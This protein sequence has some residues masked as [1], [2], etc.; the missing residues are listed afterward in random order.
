MR[1]AERRMARWLIAFALA[2]GSASAMAHEPVARCFLLDETTVR[3]RGASNDGDAMPGARM[4]VVAL[5]GT[6]LVEGKLDAQS[7][8]T[9]S[10]PAQPFYVLLDTGPGL[11]VTVEQ[12]EITA[13]PPGRMPRWM[14]RP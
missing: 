1:R 11:Q 2:L 10:K 3:C 9:F 5:D 14:R 4:E 12:E 13:P 6:T 7:T 8:L